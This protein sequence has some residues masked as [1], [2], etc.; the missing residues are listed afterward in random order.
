MERTEAMSYLKEILSTCSEM[1]PNSVSFEQTGNGEKSSIFKLHIKG[2]M[3]DTD[4][5]KV[6]NI[7][8]KHSLAVQEEHD[9]VV[10]YKP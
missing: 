3:Q 5:E 6:K 9:E 8:E 10:V 7:A 4:K 1:S 2:K